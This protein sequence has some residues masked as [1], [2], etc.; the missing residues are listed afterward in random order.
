MQLL[1]SHDFV[2]LYSVAGYIKPVDRWLGVLLPKLKPLLYEN[3]GPVILTQVCTST[4]IVHV[5]HA[6]I[7]TYDFV[8]QQYFSLCNMFTL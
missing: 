6:V 7:L 2:I 3:G 1:D 5:I 8:V 4:S